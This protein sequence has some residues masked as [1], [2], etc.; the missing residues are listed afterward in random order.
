MDVYNPPAAVIAKRP[1]QLPIDRA[2]TT[3]VSQL[4]GAPEV[5]PEYL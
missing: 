5:M 2:I 1:I 3:P 4:S